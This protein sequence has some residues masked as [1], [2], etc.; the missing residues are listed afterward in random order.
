MISFVS[1]G[2]GGTSNGTPPPPPPVPDFSL[3]AEV[4]T[5]NLQQQGAYQLQSIVAVLVSGFHGTINLSVSGLPAGV[6]TLPGSLPALQAPQVTI[7]P[8]QLLASLSAPIGTSTVTVTGTS[9]SITHSVTFS[10]AVRAAAPFSIKASP[11]SISIV[12]SSTKTVQVSAVGV[13]P[14]LST[15]TSTLP[16][17]SGANIQLNPTNFLQFSVVAGA[18]AQPLQNFPIVVTA[19]DINNSSNSSV[20]IVPLTISVPSSSVAPTRT[21]FARTDQDPTGVVY[22]QARKLLFVSVETLN[23]VAVLSSVDGHRV[24]T[25]PVPFPAGIDEAADGSAVYVV[26]PYF[27]KITTIDPNLLQ[28][29]NQTSLPQVSKAV[30]QTGFQIATL[31]NG[32]VLVL[33]ADQDSNGPPVYLWDPANNTFTGLGQRSFVSFGQAIVRSADHSKVLV[34]RVNS[35][36][37]TVFLFDALTNQLT[38]P[39]D[40]SGYAQAI[41]PD[42]SRIVDVGLQNQPTVFYDNQ[43]NALGSVALSAFPIHGAIY[44][45]DGSRVYVLQDD[46]FSLASVAAV[47]DTATFS[48]TGVVSSFNFGALLPFSG[49][50]NTAFAVD[51]TGMIFGPARG[52][53]GYLDVSSPGFLSL[54]LSSGAQLSPTL[55]SLSAPTPAQMSGLFSSAQTYNA[56]FGAAPASPLTRKATN[57]SVRSANMLDLTVPI[58]VAAGP[59]NVTLTRSD[60]FFQVIPDAVTFGPTVLGVDANAGSPSGGDS[61]EVIGYGFEGA[62][63]QVTIGGNPATNIQLRPSFGGRFPTERI[64]L[65]TPAGA[66]GNADVTVTTSDGSTTVSDGFQYLNSIQIYPITGALDSIV[67]DQTRQ[68]LYLTNQ[69]HNRVEIFDLSTRAFLSPITVGRQPTALAIT[70]DGLL[71][72][73]VNSTD[74][75]ISVVDLTTAHVVATYPALTAADASCGGQLLNLSPAVPHRMLVDLN[76]ALALATGNFHLIDLDTGSLSCAG[77]VGCSSDGTSF[78]FD[79]GLAAMAST[80][81][82][83]RIFLADQSG[84]SGQPVGMLNLVANTLATGFDGTFGDVAAN[85]DGNTFAASFGIANAQLSRT[86]IMAYEPYAD[87][88]TQ[89]GHN[90]VGEKLNPSGSLLFVPQDTGV[91]IFDVH[92]GRL[93]Q[94]VVLPEPIPSDTNAMALDETGTR[95]FLISNSGITLAQLF[96]APLSLA[97]VNPPAGLTGTHVTLRGSGFQNGATVKFGASLASVVY[98]DQNTLTTTVPALSAGPIPITVTNPDG[99]Q[100]GFDAAFTVQ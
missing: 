77:V 65:K 64:D 37:T 68:K 81:D 76:C 36:G 85:A 18:L 38:G 97:S 75:T 9:G 73:A 86:S 60:G 2:G 33:L 82:G 74:G 21:T 6:S 35:S 99:H 39:F 20:V 90:L 48:M 72:A 26:S 7:S 84:T 51:E 34:S 13:V 4:S 22:D 94:H 15:S 96:Q 32:S 55:A 91:D 88:G 58:G 16:Q 63:V 47:I 29:V 93:A 28:V 43:F 17:N 19:T 95:M 100:Y 8:F 3:Q 10:V 5:I 53:L 62:N 14:T 89:S 31:S 78:V 92:T 54:P 98:V 12:P 59:A 61:I 46:L 40:L 80:P 42:G 71:L 83:G 67:Y 1:C 49:L 41:S 56:Y 52:G 66:P 45:L 30:V 44:S 23:E 11:A 50:V 69:D 87:S 79:Q 57:V 27:T 24:T 70:P 25:I